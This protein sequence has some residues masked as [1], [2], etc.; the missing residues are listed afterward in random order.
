MPLRRG[1]RGYGDVF[2]NV[3][4]S[5]TP[6]RDASGK[7]VQI[8]GSAL[9]ITDRLRRREEARRHHEELTHVLR[10]ATVGEMAA[11]LGTS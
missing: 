2:V 1:A 6:L 8:V 3:D 4:V 10:V 9:D 5:L 11:G 7:V